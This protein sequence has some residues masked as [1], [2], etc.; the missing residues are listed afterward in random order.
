MFWC[1]STLSDPVNPMRELVWRV[2]G[3]ATPFRLEVPPNQKLPSSDTQVR[4]FQS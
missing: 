1:L 2:D 4:V 3:Y